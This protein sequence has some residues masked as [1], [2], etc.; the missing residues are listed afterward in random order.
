LLAVLAALAAGLHNMAFNF[1]PGGIYNPKPI[2]FSELANLP[3]AFWQGQAQARQAGL[4]DALAQG[5]PTLP[6]GSIDWAQAASIV[7]RYDPELGMRTAAYAQKDV[8]TPY[9]E[10]MLGV[11][12]QNSD[13]QAVSPD[14]RLWREWNE[15]NK[16]SEPMRAGPAEPSGVPGMS[17]QNAPAFIQKKFMSIDDQEAATEEGR[18]AGQNSG[19]QR[20]REMLAPRLE[21]A[22][23]NMSQSASQF[24]KTSFENALG[25]LQGSDPNDGIVTKE[26][27]RAARFGG[28]VLNWAEGGDTPTYE[29]RSKILGDANALSLAIKPMVRN[30]GEGVW[31]DKDQAILDRLVGDLAEAGTPDEYQRR[32]GYVVDRIN[33]TYGL[34]MK[35]PAAAGE[36]NEEKLP[37]YDAAEPEPP[38][39]Q[40]SV[41]GAPGMDGHVTTSDPRSGYA[42]SIKK[43]DGPA[44]ARIRNWAAEA[45]AAGVPRDV[46]MK[47]LEELGYGQ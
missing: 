26:L 30:P 15:M 8:L 11:A 6:D 27:G 40:G 33:A 12:Q 1:N 2:D 47:R 3:D 20:A 39:A 36:K 17:L 7:G 31:S 13:R 42:K 25:P 16:G 21:A 34:N 45:I 29:V 18:V 46:V 19:M 14:M 44:I 23:E 43:L 28:S 10:G 22:I 9:Q 37:S 41:A 32:L 5:L 24:D 35:R 38:A 4:R